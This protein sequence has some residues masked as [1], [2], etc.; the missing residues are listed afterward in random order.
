MSAPPVD[1]ALDAA[2]DRE[3]RRMALIHRRDLARVRGGRMP[4]VPAAREVTAARIHG[5]PGTPS[6]GP[7][8]HN[9]AVSAIRPA[10][11]ADVDAVVAL[12]QSAYR[13][14]ASRA[15]WTS[16]ADLLDGG[17]TDAS[18]VRGLI[19]DA[20]GAV[21]VLDASPGAAG[22]LACCHVQRRERTT[23]VGM[24]AVRPTA[25]GRGL[26]TAMLTAAEERARAWGSERLELTVLNHRPEL[27]AWYV[28]HGF[29]MTGRTVP[30]PYGDERF[31]IP[32]RDDLV[33]Q[34]MEKVLTGAS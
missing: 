19:R 3:L 33:L 31:G 30:F 9:P 28:R 4:W 11:S 20:D 32:R 1:Q 24:F 18:M 17:R 26:G 15:G 5:E 2:T 13:G 23:Y 21:L 10:E 7:T 14:D 12:V 6:P 25:Q 8:G 22:L 27:V 34:H 29:A 16:E